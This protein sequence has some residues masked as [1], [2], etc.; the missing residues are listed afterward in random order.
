MKFK[1]HFLPSKLNTFLYGVFLFYFVWASFYPAD[2][3]Y[4]LLYILGIIGAILLL[5]DLYAALSH[6]KLEVEFVEK[7]ARKYKGEEG[8]MTFK[9]TQ[10]GLLPIVGAALDI[11][12]SDYI[13]F[14]GDKKKRSASRT[15]KRLLF[16]VMPKRSIHVSAKYIAIERG[17]SKVFGSTLSYSNLF[18]FN[19]IVLQ[20]KSIDSTEVIVYPEVK[21]SK[22][23]P[24]RLR[25]V[26][27][28][29]RKQ[30]ALFQDKIL[31][32][33]SKDY[34]RTDQLR[35]IHWKESARLGALRTNVYEQV[36]DLEVLIIVNLRSD[37]SY[38]AVEYIEEIYEKIA[39][40][41][42]QLTRDKIPYQL[43]SNVKHIHLNDYLHVPIGSGA[44]HYKRTLEFLARLKSIDFTVPFDHLVRSV[45]NLNHVPSHLIFT[46]PTDHKINTALFEL[47]K[48]QIS[49]YQLDK[50][51][52]VEFGRSG[53]AR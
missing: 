39:Y 1:A 18:G 9:I 26:E 7:S 53:G 47:Q 22:F 41:S 14:A 37:K 45:P 38:V 48:R 49:V 40:I 42:Y 21:V 34:V 15:H 30:N 33:A 8:V 23:K 25:N 44:N 43:I 17:V 29:Y 52:L 46:G 4:T 2:Y 36:T 27:G 10:H 5:S 6:R 16:S 19:Q 51:E 32:V 11:Y 12:A 24:F 20:Q 13:I 3:S 35:D 50:Y 31:K 28:N